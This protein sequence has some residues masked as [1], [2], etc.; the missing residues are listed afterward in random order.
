M[1]SRKGSPSKTQNVGVEVVKTPKDKRSV[2]LT[3]VQGP[4]ARQNEL[5]R[6][7]VL[8]F[9]SFMHSGTSRGRG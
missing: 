2:P 5:T 1:C 3:V 9:F 4:D 7:R 8:N 6:G